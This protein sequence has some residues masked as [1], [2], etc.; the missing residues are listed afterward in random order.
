[1]TNRVE[2]EALSFVARVAWGVIAAIGGLL[3]WLITGARLPLQNLWRSSIQHSDMPRVL[4]PVSQYHGTGIVALLVVGGVVAGLVAAGTR[5]RGHSPAP[6]LGGLV[7]VQALAIVQSF[8]ALRVGLGLGGVEPVDARAGLY[9]WGMLAGTV[10]AGACAA[11][12]MWLLSRRSRNAAALGLLLAAVPLG[13]WIGEW[14]AAI[15]GSS[16]PPLLTPHL[17]RWV[18]ALVVAFALAW[19][20]VGS[21][22]KIM[23][24]GVGALVLIF[25]PPTLT[26][27]NAALGTA[28]LQGD[29]RATA[30]MIFEVL[31]ASAGTGVLPALAAFGLAALGLALHRTMGPDE[32][33]R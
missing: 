17:V 28:M 18:P 8:W 15:S 30:A 13:L 14:F 32:P 1:M 6:V 16:G 23:P 4:L 33:S 19:S 7:T 27:V 10:L 20:G 22:S 11:V 21:V 9:W 12:V 3:P 26:A 31:G 2:I 5:R 25:V 29:P 24:W